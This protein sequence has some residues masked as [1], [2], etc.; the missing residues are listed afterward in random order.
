MTR[1]CRT[2]VVLIAILACRG[3][4]EAPPVVPDVT[5]TPTPTADLGAPAVMATAPGELAVV[6]FVVAG[7]KTTDLWN[8]V[9]RAAQDTLFRHAQGNYEAGWIIMES[10]TAGLTFRITFTPHGSDSTRIALSG[11]RYVGESGR[12]GFIL[13]GNEH[14]SAIVTGDRA[15]ARLRGEAVR[16]GAGMEVE[17]Q[18]RAAETRVVD[19]RR[20]GP[21]PFITSP[22]SD[23]SLVRVLSDGKLGYCRANTVRV[24][25]HLDSLVI[26]D[27]ARRPEWCPR[28]Y[29][30]D[31]YNTFIVADPRATA[32]G[33]TLSVCAYLGLPRRFRFELVGW[34]SDSTRCPYDASHR[35][36][37]E[38]NMALL[39]RIQ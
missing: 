23:D 26:V 4:V 14:W 34:Y 19:G 5:Q 13:A 6:S 21:V 28:P 12:A 16:I 35:Q 33:D 38:P 3:R 25:N 15:V 18:E 11:A 8:L 32:V 36:R 17:R 9:N 37:S 1:V 10:G 31:G 29:D 30:P 27:R 7:P 22:V 2:A 24:G 20:I 39:R